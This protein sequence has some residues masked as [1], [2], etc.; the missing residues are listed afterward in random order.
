MKIFSS[1]ILISCCTLISSQENWTLYQKEN[2]EST[3]N[4]EKVSILNDSFSNPIKKHQLKDTSSVR[5]ITKNGFLSVNKDVRIDSLNNFL[6]EYGS[7]NLYSVQISFSQETDE[8]RKLRKKF[9]ESHPNEI[10]Y[11]EYTAPNIFLYAGKF[12]SRNDAILL[13]KKLEHS[14]ENTMIVKRSFPLTK[15]Q[16]E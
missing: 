11:D 3:T 10:L 2:I 1:I 15:P 5:Y 4:N 12:Q 14:F 16:I 6:K 8:I 13:K 9:I 7:Y